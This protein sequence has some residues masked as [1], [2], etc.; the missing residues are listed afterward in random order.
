MLAAVK[1]KPAAALKGAGLD[2]RCARRRSRSAGRDEKMSR[3][4]QKM[5]WEEEP[6]SAWPASDPRGANATEDRSTRA[7]GQL[8]RKAADQDAGLFPIPA[9]LA[10]QGIA[11]LR[12]QSRER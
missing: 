8:R 11:L 6:G 3:P 10:R 5:G 12:Q 7:T 9:G 4:N 1:T 2:G